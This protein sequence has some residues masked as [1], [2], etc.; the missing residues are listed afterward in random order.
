MKTMKST[1][2][3]VREEVALTAAG[4]ERLGAE[5]ERLVQQTSE[6][7]ERMRQEFQHKDE[8]FNRYFTHQELAQVQGRI[9][10]IRAVLDLA[11]EAFPATHDGVV[12]VGS[13]VTVRDDAGR[14]QSFTIVSPIEMDASLGYISF[15]SPVGSALLGKEEGDEVTVA[16][17]RGE[18]R[19]TIVE[20][21]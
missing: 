18:R 7:D 20:I 4:R 10:E 13:K 12:A 8:D 3:A 2:T 11:P 14:E 16:V 6:L 19:L 15:T 9:A 1:K 21:D 17:P 5:L